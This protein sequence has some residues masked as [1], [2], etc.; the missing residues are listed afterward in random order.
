MRGV[1]KAAAPLGDRNAGPRA[2]G[3][4]TDW[5]DEAYKLWRTA[6]ALQPSRE[7]RGTSSRRRGRALEAWLID[8]GT[9]DG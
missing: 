1:V 8:S 6:Q 7:Q 4:D 3:L 9:G 5:E 2:E